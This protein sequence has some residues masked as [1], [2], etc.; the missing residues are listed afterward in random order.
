MQLVERLVDGFAIRVCV[1][2][3]VF[4][5]LVCSQYPNGAVEVLI[6]PKPCDPGETT[7][8]VRGW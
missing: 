3:A 4:S 6:E 7:N 2:S 8:V 1:S 5:A